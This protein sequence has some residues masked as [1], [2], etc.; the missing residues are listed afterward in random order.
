MFLPTFPDSCVSFCP[1]LDFSDLQE[2]TSSAVGQAVQTQYAQKIVILLL[3]ARC[4]VVGVPSPMLLGEVLTKPSNTKVKPDAAL[5][6]RKHR[7]QV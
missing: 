7:A 5:F 3:K 6:S 2:K 1:L 4:R